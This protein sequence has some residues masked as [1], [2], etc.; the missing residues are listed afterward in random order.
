MRKQIIIITTI[1]LIIFQFSLFIVNEDQK[2]ILIRFTKLVKDQNNTAVLL[3]PGLHFKIPFVDVAK[4]LDTR[5]HSMNIKA[6]H[7]FSKEQKEIIVDY[8]IKW[9]VSNFE[10]YYTSTGG[11]ALQIEKL[12]NLISNDVIRIQIAKLNIKD[13]INDLNNKL[14]INVR[15]ALNDINTNQRQLIKKSINN[16]IIFNKI[17]KLILHFDTTK[18]LG[19]KVIDIQINNI[20]LPH[21]ELNYVFNNIRSERY[22]LAQNELL[23]GQNKSQKLKNQAD[24]KAILMLNQAK[25]DA[26]MIGVKNDLK[27]SKMLTNAFGK[28][29]EFY[30]FIH[31]LKNYKMIVD[32]TKDLIVLSLN[33]DFFK[34][35]K[36]PF[37]KMN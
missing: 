17:N 4:T 31:S 24:Y 8:Y 12:L 25:N 7:L 36:N 21:N 35:I 29:I 9:R 37:N 2:A 26:L 20:T 34:Y 22:L 11:N 18:L 32:K 19:I 14:T 28:N 33:S 1:T 30:I 27:I 3:E 6:T 10:N 16:K 13:I 23:D 5:I 15:N